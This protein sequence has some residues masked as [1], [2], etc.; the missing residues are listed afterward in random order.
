MDDTD[1]AESMPACRLA[2]A[3][4]LGKI[5]ELMKVYAHSQ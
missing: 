2:A 4:S 5:P 3:V 1:V